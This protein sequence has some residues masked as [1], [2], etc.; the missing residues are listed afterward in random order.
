[1]LDWQEL[2]EDWYCDQ[3]YVDVGDVFGYFVEQ[4]CDGDVGQFECGE[5]L[6]VGDQY[7]FSQIEMYYGMVCCGVVGS[8]C[9]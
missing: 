6:Q 4:Q 8:E 1:M 7:F 9:C 5:F 3:W 2:V